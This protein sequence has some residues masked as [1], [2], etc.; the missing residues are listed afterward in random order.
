MID[1]AASSIPTLDE[2]MAAPPADVARVA[3]PSMV[4]AAA[5]TRR[6]AAMA[7]FSSSSDAFAEWSRVE[8]LEAC[9]LIFAFGVQH[10]FTIL[11]AP[12]QFREVGRYRERLIAWLTWGLTGTEARHDFKQLGWRVRVITDE[13]NAALRDIRER[14]ESS[15]PAASRHTLW[16]LIVPDAEDPWCW[17]LNAALQA[18]AHDRA[19]LIHALYGEDVPLIRLFLG[20]GKP[21]LSP[22]LLPPVLADTVHCYWTQRPGYALTDEEF[23]RIL[24]DFA[25][26]RPTWR[27]DKT[28]RAEAILSDRAI[29]QESLISGPGPAA[30]AILVS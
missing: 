5:G 17:I 27:A 2:F 13:T 29:W 18:Q 16:F 21:A 1:L 23:R 22:V 9:K 11:A 8:M 28:G 4:Y 30:G 3:P 10:L 7:G 12:S 20:F 14:V 25:Y 6:S 19:G 15:S 26:L 24:Y